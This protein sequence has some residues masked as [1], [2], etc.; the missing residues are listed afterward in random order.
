MPHRTYKGATH[1]VWV[2]D[3]PQIGGVSHNIITDISYTA[4]TD[5]ENIDAMLALDNV[6][7]APV[8]TINYVTVGGNLVVVV[9]NTAGPLDRATWSLDLRRARRW[10]VTQQ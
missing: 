7:G 10:R 9:A 3:V 5:P 4:S 2:E 8:F 1:E 6:V